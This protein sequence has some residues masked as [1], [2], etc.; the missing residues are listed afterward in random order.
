MPVSISFVAAWKGVPK[1]RQLELSVEVSPNP[2]EV[3]DNCEC[4]TMKSSDM[5]ASTPIVAMTYIAI[6]KTFDGKMVD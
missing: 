4:W 1:A 6:H 2:A 5:I 3:C